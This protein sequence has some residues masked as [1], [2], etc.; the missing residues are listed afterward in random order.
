MYKIINND[1]FIN[2]AQIL[3]SA[4]IDKAGVRGVKTGFSALIRSHDH[5]SVTF[6]R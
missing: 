3:Q 6:L 4:L 2:V 1:T 5:M